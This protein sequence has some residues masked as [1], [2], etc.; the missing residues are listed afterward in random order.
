MKQAADRKTVTIVSH[1]FSRDFAG[2]TIDG[3]ASMIA[4]FRWRGLNDCHL[5]HAAISPCA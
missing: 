5:S 4:I 3:A 1:R 2:L